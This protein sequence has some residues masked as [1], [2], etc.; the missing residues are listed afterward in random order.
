VSQ[1]DPEP[2]AAPTRIIAVSNQKGGV[3]KTTTAVNLATALAAS[4]CAVLLIDLDP[5]GNASTGLGIG[6]EQRTLG[7]YCVLVLHTPP[8]DAVRPSGIP[9]LD[10]IPAEPDLAGAEIE[11]VAM[12]RRQT[13]LRD[14]L[15]PLRAGRPRYDYVIIDCPP[16]LGLLTINA[17][18]AASAVLV[19]LQCEF[20]ALE[21]ISGLMRTIEA[22][23]RGY[24]PSLRLSG[25]VLTM[26]DKR[27]NLA[28]QV[29]ADARGFFGTSVFETIIPRNIRITEAPSYG[30]P[31]LLYDFRSPGAQAYVRL[32][33][34][35]LRRERAAGAGA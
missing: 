2:A 33:A 22:V 35:L 9:N 6:P 25:I 19:P 21:G 27:N 29:A 23:R 1:P 30:K 17:L 10:V 7:S 11:L 28:E 16:S 31:V 12:D 18:V 24:N 3:G 34:E 14:A 32:A 20:Y 4:G 8:E 5:Q 26:F 15:A 13:R